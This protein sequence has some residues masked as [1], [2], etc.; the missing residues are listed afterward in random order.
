[1]KNP[2]PSDGEPRPKR[3]RAK[4]LAVRSFCLVFLTFVLLFGALATF[5]DHLNLQS[6]AVIVGLA[7]ITAVVWALAAVFFDNV[8]PPRDDR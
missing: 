8:P 4:R 3:E 2:Q 5:N 7:L 1:M 6:A